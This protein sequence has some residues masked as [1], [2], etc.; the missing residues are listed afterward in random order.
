ME[1]LDNLMNL[2]CELQNNSSRTAKEQILRDNSENTLFTEVLKFLYNPFIVT[3]LSSSKINKNVTGALGLALF[4]FMEEDNENLLD[5]LNYLK[6]HNTGRDVD[7]NKVRTYIDRN[8]KF[9]D[10]LK[11]IFTKELKLGI[12]STTL[13]KVY[14]KG[15]VP[16]FDVMLAENYFDNKNFVNEKEFILTEKLDGNRCVA[17]Y[18]NDQVEFFT[19]Q[20]QPYGE[21][22]QIENE[23]KK[24]KCGYVY[25]G[26]LIAKSDNNLTTE[27]LFRLSTS[28]VRK[29]G[30]KTDVVFHIFDMVPI[31]DFKSGISS[32]NA[33]ERK[34]LLH[35]TIAHINPRLTKPSEWV[36]EVEMLY[37]GR[38]VN[39][40]YYNLEKITSKG[41]EGVMI[42]LS[43]GCYECK[44]TKQLLKVKKFRTADVR[45]TG[46]YEGTGKNTG[47]LGGIY[48]EFEHL[49]KKWNCGVGSG[50][51][52]EERELYWNNKEMLLGKIVEVKYF[53]I[54]SDADG[55]YSMRFPVW[56]GRIREDKNE[57][58]MY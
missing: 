10:M 37:V 16:T 34:Y 20:G 5:I 38:N 49:G 15:F 29:D 47:R 6:E 26:E 30:V 23:I 21:M 41:G 9:E 53:E 12:Q 32:I 11:K 31:E 55:N 56:L 40:I 42:N 46:V 24:L 35:D 58:S 14:G 50:F 28:K 19:R 8:I 54:S 22:P 48:I 39:E 18:E 51:T 52:D 7:I 33:K 57:I 45:V 43:D 36:E 27:E 3:G 25:D 4:E 1:S 13:N 17:V 2:F 44:R